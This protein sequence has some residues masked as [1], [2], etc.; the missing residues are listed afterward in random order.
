MQ[1]PAVRSPRSQSTQSVT[2]IAM[3][4]GT[5]V[6]STMTTRTAT[7]TRFTSSS[8]LPRREAQ[9]CQPEKGVNGLIW[10]GVPS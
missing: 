1:V 5:P 3:T 8:S 7:R 6:S 9:A 10:N 2:G 4:K